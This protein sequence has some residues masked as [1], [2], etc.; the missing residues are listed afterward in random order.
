[1]VGGS[2]AS[3]ADPTPPE[4][5]PDPG[6]S[7]VTPA[8]VRSMRSRA[9][10]PRFSAI[11][12][13][14]AILFLISPL[15]A[16]GSDSHSALLSTLPFAAILA[17]AAIGQ[18]LVIQQ[19]GLDLTVPAMIT[20]TTII[21]TRY[22]HGSDSRLPAAIGI[23]VLACVASGL[24][25]GFAITWLGITPL[26]ATL[27]VNAL[28]TG[29]VLQITSGASTS[30]APSGL[31][32]FALEKTFGIPNTVLIAAAAVALVAVVMR[33]TVIGRR[34]VSVGANPAA[35]HV[36]GVRV[37]AYELGTYVLAALA[38]GGAG[39]LVAGYL[40]T[41]GIGAGDTYLLPTIAAVVLGGTSL[42]GGRGSVVATAAG[43]LFLTQLEQVVLGMGAPDSVQLVLQG[44]IIAL[45]MAIRNVPLGAIRRA[46]TDL[47]LGGSPPQPEPGAGVGHHVRPSS[48]SLG[49]AE[50]PPPA[51]EFRGFPAW[52]GVPYHH[53]RPS[54]S[55]RSR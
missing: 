51:E 30:T 47:R 27:G 38:Y 16:T 35:A 39:I 11:W 45:G 46:M 40:G 25:S 7:S 2:L 13:A 10:V 32:N 21:V 19:R 9:R 48:L 43:A 42:A 29:V 6:D 20:L 3:P 8:G 1:M 31:A 17:I 24:V 53:H 4:D 41:P 22:P 26:V 50:D 28:L 34:F 5:L 36:A 37:K 18:T 14:T 54:G 44:V 52:S 15:L 12:F 49:G 55:R 23:V 33:T